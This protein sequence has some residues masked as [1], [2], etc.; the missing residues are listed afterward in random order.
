MLDTPKQY[1]LEGNTKNMTV[2][3]ADIRNF[4]PIA[5]KLDASGVKKFLNTLFTPL[6]KIIFEFQG[7][8]DKYVGDMIMAFWNDPIEDKAHATHSVKAALMMQE[9]VKELA[10]VFAA[11]NLPNVSIRIGINTGIM[12]VGDMGSEYRKAYTVLGDA[13]NVASRLEGA[14]K[15]YGTD[16]LISQETKDQCN[17]VVFRFVD[18][19]YVK[20][21]EKPINI[22]EPLG[23]L[24]NKTAA[25]EA[26]LSNYSKA[27]EFYNAKNWNQAKEK[28]ESLSREYPQSQ[29]YRIYRDRAHEYESNP[30]PSD[31]D[32]GQHLTEK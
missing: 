5:E 7:T 24:N 23:L 17:D 31:W 13:V 21:K 14:N 4:T 26:E 27:L 1:T 29:L 9:K 18:C 30:P 28:F 32:G 3:F 20:G 10:S 11:Q 8:I 19:I 12:H 6:T 16:I 15:F 2:L 25:L 22:Y